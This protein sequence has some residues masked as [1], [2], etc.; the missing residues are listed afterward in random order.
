MPARCC[1]PS[2]LTCSLGLPWRL[3]L[4]WGKGRS[5]RRRRPPVLGMGGCVGG[6]VWVRWPRPCAN[7]ESECC[8]RKQARRLGR[9]ELSCMVMSNRAGAA[10][11]SGNL[12]PPLVQSMGCA[13]H[14]LAPPHPLHTIP[15]SLETEGDHRAF[16]RVQPGPFSSSLSPPGPPLEHSAPLMNG[17]APRR[18]RS[19]S[20]RWAC[21]VLAP[22]H[23]TPHD[24][25]P[26][27][28]P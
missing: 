20:N 4:C 10:G 3:C 11:L 8:M 5:R 14:A 24:A 12:M 6:W 19:L 26:L 27:C 2:C 16:V 28:L 25:T 22:P 7:E 15:S 21:L 13:P 18:R 1:C 17:S 23:A 9:K